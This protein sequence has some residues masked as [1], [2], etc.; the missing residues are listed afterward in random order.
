MIILNGVESCI[1][2]SFNI[3]TTLNTTFFLSFEVTTKLSQFLTTMDFFRWILIFV[4]LK[5]LLFLN[6]PSVLSYQ[7]LTSQYTL[8]Y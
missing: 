8:Q 6:G 3:E 5:K 1:K 4:S 7:Q 2:I